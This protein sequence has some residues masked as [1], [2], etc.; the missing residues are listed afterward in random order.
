[1]TGWL[2]GIR[3]QRRRKSPVYRS[4]QDKKNQLELTASFIIGRKFSTYQSR[5]DQ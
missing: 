3:L 4:I 5:S 2:G 1:M